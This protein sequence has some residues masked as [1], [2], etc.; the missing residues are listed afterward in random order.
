MPKL[1]LTAI[2][3]IAVA[4]ASLIAAP[5]AVA[6]P[7]LAP[8]ALG[9]VIGAAARLAALPIIAA[10][11]ASSAGQPP[12]VTPAPYAY[13]AGYAP[14]PVGYPSAGYYGPPAYY[15]PPPAYYAPSPVGY[16]GG[17]RYYPAA[18][19]RNPAPYGA[20]PRPQSFPRYSVAGMRYSG[21][22]GG[23]IFSRSRGFAHRRW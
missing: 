23:A 12:P 15:V 8:W 16:Y 6:G 22:Y 5:A 2:S 20:M 19:Y 3:A 13:G 7:W 11:A 17:P 1:K 10:S 4:L 14:P 9:H 18:A 21:A